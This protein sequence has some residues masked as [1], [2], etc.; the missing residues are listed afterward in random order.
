MTPEARAISG[1]DLFRKKTTKMSFANFTESCEHMRDQS[2]RGALGL[3]LHQLQGQSA[4]ANPA[5]PFIHVIK[6]SPSTYCVPDPKAN[7][8]RVP[9][10]PTP[11]KA[12]QIQPEV[13]A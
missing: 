4:P 8:V 1:K 7:T 13:A 2:K 12:L 11:P 3:T 5:A 10:P 9:P 6:H